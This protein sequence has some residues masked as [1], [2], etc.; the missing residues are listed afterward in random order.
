[1]DIP[2]FL[3]PHGDDCVLEVFVQP[4]AAKQAVVGIHGTALKVRVTAPPVDNRANRAVEALIAGLLG[5][6]KGRVTVVAGHSSRHKRL[7]IE[8]VAASVVAGV[9]GVSGP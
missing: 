6:P 4:R 1:M 9:L 5:V 3:T 7:E 2:P 8:G